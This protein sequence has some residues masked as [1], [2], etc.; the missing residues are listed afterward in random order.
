MDL[1]TNQLSIV[2]RFVQTDSSDVYYIAAYS[3]LCIAIADLL[4]DYEV[5]DLADNYSPYK[6]FLN[7]IAENKLDEKYLDKN[8]FSVQKDAFKSFVQNGYANERYDVPIENETLYEKSRYKET[9]CGLIKKIHKKNILVLNAQTIFSDT[10]EILE[11]LENIPLNGK[12]VFCF[13]SEN[14][15]ISTISALNFLERCSTKMN[16]LLLR[17]AFVPK[18]RTLC[19]KINRTYTEKNEKKIFN[20]IFMNLRNNRIF[21]SEDQLKFCYDKYS[22]VVSKESFPDEQSRILNFELGLACFALDQKDETVNYM[23]KVVD[24]FDKD[25]LATAAYYYLARCFYYKKSNELAVKFLTKFYENIGEDKSNPYYA[26]AAMME[27]QFI[28]RSD[29]EQTIKKYNT[30]L[31]ELENHGFVNNY[32]STSLS[33]PWDLINHNESLTKIN[34]NIDKCYKLAIKIGNQHLISKACHWKGIMLSH[35]GHDDAAMKWYNEC[36]KIRT[37]IGEIIPIINIRNGLSYAF[38]SRAEFE[39]AYDIVNEIIKNLYNMT[40]YSTVIDTLKNVGYALFFGRNYDVAYEIFS[41]IQRYLNLFNMAS[42]T[43]N[44]FLPSMTDILIYKTIIDLDKG[45]YIHG[46]TNFSQIYENSEDITSEDRPMVK[47][48]QAVLYA[49]QNDFENAEKSILECEKQFKEIKSNQT[50]KIVFC[51]Y[52]FALV[53]SKLGKHKKAQEY[54]TKGHYLALEKKLSYFSKDKSKIFLR[55]YSKGIKKFKPLNIDLSFLDEKAEKEVLVSAMHR[56]IYDYKFLDKIKTNSIETSTF[57]KYIEKAL[58]TIFDYAMPENISLCEYVNKKFN[59]LYSISHEDNFEFPEN[60]WQKVCASSKKDEP[61]VLVYKPEFNAY[62]SNISQLNYKMGL[63]II[64][65][66]N[67][68]LSKDNISTLN[69]AISTLQAQITIYKQEANLLFLST[70][71]QLSLLKNRHA[72]QEF[73]KIESERLLRSRQ[74]KRPVK[75]MTI[76]F[77]DMDNFKY[78]N[79]NFGHSIGDNLIIYFAQLLKNTCRQVDFVARFG[80]DEFVIVMDDTSDEEAKILFSRIKKQIEN[81][82]FFIPKL[83]ETLHQPDLKIPEKHRLGF[84]MGIASNSDIEDSSDLTSIMSF[85]DKALYYSKEHNKGSLS[86]WKEIKDKTTE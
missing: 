82:E 78:Y 11:E 40:D 23:H 42:Q 75:N 37:E 68:E 66:K 28:K 49:E 13:N 26:L 61:G 10:I 41:R 20:Q 9:I 73:L 14:D 43:N 85:A 69:I 77:I 72:L 81:E 5:I 17:N 64:P 30:A 3:S 35:Y 83:K 52:E 34:K 50:H 29:L 32:I 48:I 31:T 22:K 60:L 44:S 39:N 19:T 51:L 63:L 7:I 79:D 38:L 12:F 84:S 58:N 76:A 47:Y 53:L 6:P 25:D 55:E 33:I 57:E 74:K 45:D 18:D 4:R 62:F 70:T 27:F 65:R 24:V 80:G 54:L 21:L 59:T 67:Q 71:D 86:I 36:N 1:L 2:E 46:Q 15:E 16:F 56:R 8:S